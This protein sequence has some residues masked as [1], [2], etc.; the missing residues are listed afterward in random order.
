MVLMITN[1]H[2]SG[3]L[4]FFSFICLE[5]RKFS[6][7]LVMNSGILKCKFLTLVNRKRSFGSF[8]H[9]DRY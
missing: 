4:S 3:I 6:M 5:V 1:T 2:S 9:I 7:N 8:S